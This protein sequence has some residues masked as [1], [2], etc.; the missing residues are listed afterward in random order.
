[1]VSEVISCY[2]LL[3]ILGS[4]EEGLPNRN[5]YYCVTWCFLRRAMLYVGEIEHGS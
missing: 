3:P 4:A 5:P 1:M 2:I